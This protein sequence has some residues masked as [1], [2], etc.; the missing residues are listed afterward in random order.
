MSELPKVQALCYKPELTHSVW[1]D[2]VHGMRSE[3]SLRKYCQKMVRSGEWVGYRF[4]TL[5]EQFIGVTWVGDGGA[6]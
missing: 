3:K 1:T 2:V 5:H 4:I 6:K